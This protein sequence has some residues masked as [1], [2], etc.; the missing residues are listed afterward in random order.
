M[1]YFVILTTCC[2]TLLAWQYKDLEAL[3]IYRSDVV[4][5][6]SQ[7]YRFITNGLLHASVKHLGGNMVT[8]ALAG[9][10]LLSKTTMGQVRFLGLYI[11]GL[12]VSSYVSYVFHKDV[13]N[14]LFIEYGASGAVFAVVSA[15]LLLTIRSRFV[16]LA[17]IT[18]IGLLEY[19]SIGVNDNVGHVAHLVGIIY[20]VAFTQ[21]FVLL[22]KHYFSQR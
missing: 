15:N 4:T 1:L 5:D 18:F 3:L 9:F 21:L 20:G 6:T 7:W 19:R 12:F 2:T 14:V 16:A 17:V 10:M 13:V 11:T 8:L 22:P